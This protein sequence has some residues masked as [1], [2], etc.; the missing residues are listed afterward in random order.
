MATT[1]LQAGPNTPIATPDDVAQ[2][3]ADLR[4]R[5]ASAGYATTGAKLPDGVTVR[6]NGEVV[7]YEIEPSSSPL[8]PDIVYW[9]MVVAGGT[10]FIWEEDGTN[11]ASGMLGYK[12]YD[13]NGDEMQT[14][15]DLLAD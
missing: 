14:I 7:S 3:A 2:V 12:F 10:A 8:R 9:R 11:G 6:M 4:Y 13:A 15:P 1:I 5:I